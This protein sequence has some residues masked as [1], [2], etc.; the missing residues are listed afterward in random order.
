MCDQTNIPSVT[1]QTAVL[2]QVKEFAISNTAFSVHD[3]TRDIRKKTASG[4]LEIPEVEVSG[5]SFRFNIP[6]V[7]VKAL[8][9]KLW[10]TGVFDPNFTLSRQSNGLY[11]EYTPSPVNTG[12]ATVI[13]PAVTTPAAPAP[14]VVVTRDKVTTPPTPSHSMM[15]DR[16]RTYLANC[17]NRSFRPT[18]KN[19]QSAIKRE[20]STGYTCDELKSY[21]TQI[22]YVIIDDPDA[23]SRSQVVV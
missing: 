3:I 22:G 23:I 10:R 13:P 19:I 1:L 15:V 17:T 21:I 11:F 16:I 6:H 14:A 7:M 12:P 5:A 20:V 8:F 2:L 18:I 9:D 4:E